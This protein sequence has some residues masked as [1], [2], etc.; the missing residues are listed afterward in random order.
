ML[1]NVVSTMQESKRAVVVTRTLIP[2]FATFSRAATN[3]FNDST[4]FCESDRYKIKKNIS[5]LCEDQFFKKS[6]YYGV[7]YW[8]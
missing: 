3:A 4:D 6:N 5:R 2:P 8:Q 1:E 7:G